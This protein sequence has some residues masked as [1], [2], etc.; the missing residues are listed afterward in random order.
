MRTLMETIL[1]AKN[2]GTP[3]L[4]ISTADQRATVAS[5]VES[6]EPD[7]A[8]LT[9]DVMRGLKSLNKSGTTALAK[10]GT[11]QEVDVARAPAD[12]LALAV[13]LP[14]EAMLMVY[15]AHRHV[16]EA[17]VAQAIANLRDVFKQDGRTL[18]LLAPSIEMPAELRSDVVAL[19]EPL[20]DDAAIAAI[21]R[22]LYKTG[23][24]EPPSKEVEARAVDTARGLSSFA[25]E[26]VFAMSMSKAGLDLDVAWDR[27]RAA[28]NQTKGL[29]IRRGGVKLDDLGG[30]SNAIE[31]IK[32]RAAGPRPF[33][34]VLFLDEI[35][36]MLGSA[37]GDTSGV[38]R[39][40]LGVILRTMED[41]GWDGMI[42]VGPPGCAKT[43]FASAVGA[44]FG[45][46]TMAGD[47][48]AVKGKFVGQS[49]QGIREMMK[50]AEGVGGDRVLVLA[51]C[52]S[53]DV[54][55]PEL[56]RRFKTGIWFF[57]L[58]TAAERDV[59]WAIHL[60]RVFAGL[61]ES[62]LRDRVGARPDDSDWTG[63]EIRNCVEKSWELTSS[64]VD[65]AAFIVPVAR[66]QSDVISK[67]REL[68]HGRFI[69]AAYA[70]PYDKDRQP[71]E[72]SGRRMTL[73]EDVPREFHVGPLVIPGPPSA[74]STMPKT[75]KGES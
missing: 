22:A 38:S 21:L 15:N 50:V 59:I 34:S 62:D 45:V 56:R 42:L 44:T 9:W 8:K 37:N 65:A 14:P 13:K 29:T 68:A 7:Q 49:E 47:L 33:S 70:G 4:S 51:T 48:G 6:I 3:L 28:I 57:D 71:E 19:D 53:L 17:P 31:F 40:A 41:V 67:L 73:I 16:H 27:K 12:A 36:K 39:D 55:P 64:L 20:P 10:L 75:K 43:A 30:L 2:V 60:R 63:A 26:Q 61:S 18:V 74:A 24:L 46:P 11:S 1:A 5:I 58:P 54:L 72:T 32:R 69:S 35:E 25:A 66:S 52:N 23:K